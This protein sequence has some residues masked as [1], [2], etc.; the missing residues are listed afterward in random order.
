M[1]ICVIADAPPVV[2]QKLR[3]TDTFCAP[4]A[5]MNGIK[6]QLP[7]RADSFLIYGLL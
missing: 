1:F 7:A 6:K 5:P 2:K 4:D 3:C